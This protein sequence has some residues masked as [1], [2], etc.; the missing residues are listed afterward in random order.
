MV[1]PTATVIGNWGKSLPLDSY[2]KRDI[3]RPIRPA[4]GT[5]VPAAEDELLEEAILDLK[6][7][8]EN[9]AMSPSWTFGE[10]RRLALTMTC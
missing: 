4:G 1:V 3:M 9:P 8:S 7:Q 10:E 5:K 2:L 6:S